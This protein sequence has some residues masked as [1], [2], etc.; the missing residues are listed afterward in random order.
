MIFVEGE[1]ED[2]KGAEAAHAIKNKILELWPEIKESKED[3]IKLVIEPH[4]SKGLV[5]S[6]DLVILGKFQN[7][8]E[9][10]LPRPIVFPKKNP[11][12]A[13]EKIRDP[14]LISIDKVKIYNFITVVEV[15]DS[16]PNSLFVKNSKV[17][18]KTRHSSKSVSQQNRNQVW[19]YQ[20]HI[21]SLNKNVRPWVS[22]AIY[23]QRVKSPPKD[24]QYALGFDD[25][26]KS[27][28]VSIAD[29]MTRLRFHREYL[30]K[31]GEAELKSLPVELFDSC[32]NAS[33]HIDNE[34][35]R[36]DAKRALE[37]SR[38]L[39]R[40]W[41]ED[42]GERSI[43]FKGPGGT[44]KTIKLLQLAHELYS[45]QRHK[46][47]V[48]TYNIALISNLRRLMT[49]M[50]IKAWD[51]DEE[52]GGMHIDS[53]MSFIS[54]ILIANGFIDVD[55]ENVLDVYEE[56]L[57]EFLVMLDEEAISG[58]ELQEEAKNMYGSDF[59]F[60]YAFIDEG[61]DWLEGEIRI[62]KEIF[63]E[64]NIVIAHGNLQETRGVEARWDK[65]LT[66]SRKDF[67]GQITIHSLWGGI[68]MTPNLGSFVK[69]FAKKTLRDDQYSKLRI[70]EESSGGNIYIVEGDYFSDTKLHDELLDR[71]EKDKAK[72]IDLLVCVPASTILRPEKKDEQI[73]SSVGN[74]FSKLG[75][76][77][78]NAVDE[79]VRASLPRSV[80][81]LRL[82]QYE[83]CRGLEGWF[84]FNFGL[85]DFWDFKIEESK[86]E[87]NS[88]SGQQSFLD[89][90]EEFAREQTAKWLL[91]ALTRS[92]DS[93]VIQ[94]NDGNHYLSQILREIYEEN[95]D[96]IEWISQ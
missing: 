27:W 11:D 7:P 6:A 16:G 68:R 41:F 38:K 2:S 81:D 89:S 39:Q 73:R 29:Q 83:S 65:N 32:F 37:I 26:F 52:I 34:L 95:K 58:K 93:T 70:N 36:L 64:K 54:K 50:G 49:L 28:I 67:K 19:A 25:S 24:A 56:K 12:L 87:F 40:N 86:E 15:K 44:G 82:V 69:D 66:V 10:K 20:E 61:Q 9:I 45:E 14:E 79:N 72:L 62:I 22:R 21:K 84:T 74:N 18:Q 43:M 31:K 92:I 42:V 59:L 91:I 17:F 85:D 1:Y 13:E 88:K 4:L 78:W 71:A 46:T 96:Y 77:L 75:I 3:N 57:D 90:P 8:K 47:L 60:D 51:F 30:T 76:N 94:L 33:Y 35:T 80:D 53:V 23:L 5:E 55:K 48:L 63:N